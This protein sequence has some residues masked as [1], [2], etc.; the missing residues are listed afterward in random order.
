MDGGW[1][2]SPSAPPRE[3]EGGTMGFAQAVEHVVD[4]GRATR[5][6]WG[7]TAVWMCMYREYLSIRLA[8]GETRALLVRDVDIV[9]KDW[10]QV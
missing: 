2:A 4:G 1:S 8:A 9:A 10:V 5:I 6:E 3:V 7:S